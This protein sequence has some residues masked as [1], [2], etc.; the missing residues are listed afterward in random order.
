M[1][2][3]VSDR[4]APFMQDGEVLVPWRSKSGLPRQ[5]IREMLILTQ[6]AFEPDAGYDDEDASA[7]ALKAQGAFIP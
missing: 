3:K 1:A 6:E 4:Q 7:Q 2:N 5:Q